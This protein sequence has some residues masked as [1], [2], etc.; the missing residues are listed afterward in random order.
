MNATT[1]LRI[2]KDCGLEAWSEED[3]D[4]FKFDK[5]CKHRRQPL[6]K[7]CHQVKNKALWAQNRN[8]DTRLN[9]YYKR[10][11]NITL[12]DVLDMKESQGHTCKICGKPEGETALTKFIVDHCHDT[13]R[14]R[15]ILCGKCNTALGHLEDDIDRLKK[16]IAYLEK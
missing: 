1:P 10:Y 15:G 7:S 2:C 13:N 14:V 4:L 12:Q 5:P 3:L 6:C 16:A 11:Y 9:T 8:E